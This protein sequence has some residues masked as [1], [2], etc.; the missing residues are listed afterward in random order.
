MSTELG[1]EITGTTSS[2]KSNRWKTVFYGALVT[3]VGVGGFSLGAWVKWKHSDLPKVESPQALGPADCG[4]KSVRDGNA[5]FDTMC[6]WRSYNIYSGIAAGVVGVVVVGSGIM[7]FRGAS[8]SS[9][10][11]VAGKARKRPQFSITPI[12]SP[13]GG[14]ATFQFDW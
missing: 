14:G 11:A 5:R 3:G 4:S 7:A 12:V 9:A 8:E 10:P 1:H 2:V 13:E 6:S